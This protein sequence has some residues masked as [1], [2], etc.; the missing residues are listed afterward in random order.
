MKRLIA[1]LSAVVLGLTL[2]SA[3]PGVAAS[4]TRD[5]W[6]TRVFS[7]VPYPGTPAY[8]FVH[9]NGRVY[10]GT[11]D[12][13]ITKASRVFE[14][15]KGGTLLRSWTVPGQDLEHS[16]GIQV[17]NQDARGRLVLLEK[18]TSAVLTLDLKTGRFK[19]QATLPDLPLCST[20][21]T[22]CSPNSSDAKA[23]PN[24]AAWGPDGALYITDYGQAVIWRIP[25]KGGTP[26]VWFSSNALDSVLEFGTTGLVY[27]ASSKSFLIAQQTVG[28]LLANAPSGRLYGLPVSKSGKPGKLTTMWTSR[29]TELPDGFG[30]GLSGKIYI[31]GVGPMNQLVVLS[32]TGKELER[33][34]KFPL[35]GDNGSSVPFDGPSNAT[36]LGTRVLVANQSPISGDRAHHVILDV[37]VGERGVPNYLPK[38]SILR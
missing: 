38:G 25:A 13:G 28:N 2:I 6:D 15:T 20:K 24:Y 33:F 35:L 10:A 36:F 11:Y 30:I 26:K 3:I 12:A 18:S 19:R 5:K 1:G 27:Q 9:T 21:V 32:Q 16:P 7:N 23:I 8:V 37:E 17:A 4:A 22:P 31:A 34:P 14:W 29:P